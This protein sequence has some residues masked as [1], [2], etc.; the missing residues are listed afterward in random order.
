MSEET[1]G[2]HNVPLLGSECFSLETMSNRKYRSTCFDIATQERDQTPGFPCWAPPCSVKL[3][4]LPLFTWIEHNFSPPGFSSVELITC[5]DNFFRDGFLLW[6]RSV[7][8][9]FTFPSEQLSYHRLQH[10]SLPPSLPSL[11]A[12]LS[13]SRDNVF[14]SLFLRSAW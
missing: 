1:P 13:N 4:R 8:S 5:C 6:V 9:E 10:A 11:T 7:L 14:S 12:N 3:F 2:L